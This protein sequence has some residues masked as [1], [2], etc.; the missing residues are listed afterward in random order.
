MPIYL[1]HCDSCHA[2]QDLYRSVANMDEDLPNCCG[3]QM[4]RKICA[5][6]VVTDIQPYRSMATGEMINSR[7][8]HKEHLRDNG[9]VEIGN[10]KPLSPKAPEMPKDIKKDLHEVMTGFGL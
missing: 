4:R 6:Y 5:P 8:K 2:E 1:M 7:S 9:L 10:E 3:E